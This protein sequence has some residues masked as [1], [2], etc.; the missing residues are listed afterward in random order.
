M[1]TFVHAPGSHTLPSCPCGSMVSI[2]QGRS[3]CS[4][5]SAQLQPVA[6][7]K[8]YTR[9]DVCIV[10]CIACA[11]DLLPQMGEWWPGLKEMYIQGHLEITNLG[12]LQLPKL[13]VRPPFMYWAYAK[14]RSWF[15]V[16]CA[17]R[18][19]ARAVASALKYAASCCLP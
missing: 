3:P 8:Q 14:L 4:C 13:Q 9:V 15:Y 18:S 7:Y 6:Q 12:A 10:C 5:V 19:K 2:G 1:H 11:Q 16:S 17:P